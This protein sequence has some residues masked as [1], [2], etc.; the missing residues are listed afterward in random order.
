MENRED[1]ELTTLIKAQ[2]TYYEAPKSLRERIGVVLARAEPDDL[3]PK[4]SQWAAWRQWWGMGA[5]FAIGMMLSVAI[6]FFYGLS[7]QQDRLM[8]QVIDNHVRSLMVAH[9]SDVTSSD[10]HTVKPWLSDKLTFSPPVYDLAPDEFPLI[11]GRLDYIDEQP[12]AA[13]VYR[14]HLHTINVFIWPVRNDSS[15]ASSSAYRHGFNVTAW[16][17]EGMQFWAVSDI[18]SADLQRFARMLR[19]QPKP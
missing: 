13:L 14:H 17:N 6:T 1:T 12:V 10:Q 7:R 4:A 11:G 15:A 19:N 2:A 8:G 16:T 18:Q 3:A 5:A 9:L